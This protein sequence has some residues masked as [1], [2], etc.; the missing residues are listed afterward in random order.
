M[1][2][3]FPNTIKNPCEEGNLTESVVLDHVTYERARLPAKKNKKSKTVLFNKRV[4]K[5]W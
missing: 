4:S 2:A 3:P 1:P 5:E